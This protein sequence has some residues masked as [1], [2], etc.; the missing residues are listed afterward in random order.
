M[1]RRLKVGTNPIAQAHGFA[2]ID[3]IAT[4]IAHQVDAR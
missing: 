2:D 4:G 1:A 3:D